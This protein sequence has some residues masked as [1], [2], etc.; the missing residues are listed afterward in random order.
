[1]AILEADAL[2]DYV[3]KIIGYAAEI[4][5]SSIGE[6]KELK[7]ITKNIIDDSSIKMTRE[8]AEKITATY[9]RGLKEL[10]LI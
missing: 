10:K 1:L 9:K 6:I 8:E 5:I 7:N 3:L 4:K 2:F